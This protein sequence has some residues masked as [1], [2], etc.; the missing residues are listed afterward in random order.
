[1][2]DFAIDISIT[3]HTSRGMR[4]VVFVTPEKGY[5]FYVD[6]DSDFKYYK[7]V[8]GGITWTG[9]TL[10]VTGTVGGFDVWF[11]QW[12]PG[13]TG[14]IIHTWCMESAFDGIYYTALNTTNDVLGSNI[15]VF[16]GISLS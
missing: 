11:D 16:D 10:I 15:V 1:M 6:G 12:T 5:S 14:S 4:A 2:A 9:P 7:T 3:T 13:D 8:N